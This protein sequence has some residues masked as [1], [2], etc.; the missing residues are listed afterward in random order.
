VRV[1]RLVASSETSRMRH[2]AMAVH[3]FLR[4]GAVDEDSRIA[5]CIG[6]GWKL[7][8]TALAPSHRVVTIRLESPITYPPASHSC[9]GNPHWACHLLGHRPARPV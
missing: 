2:H 4:E 1:H 8:R 5:H 6:T 3:R 7:R 9:L